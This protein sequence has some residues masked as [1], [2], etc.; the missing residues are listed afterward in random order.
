[1]KPAPT[2]RAATGGFP[3]VILFSVLLVMA[4][5][6]GD[7]GKADLGCQNPDTGCVDGEPCYGTSDCADE[8]LCLRENDSDETGMC[9][10]SPVTKCNTFVDRWCERNDFCETDTKELCLRRTAETIDCALATYVSDTYDDCLLEIDNLSCLILGE[11]PPSC[12]DM[13]SFQ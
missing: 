2:N 3:A 1:M 7:D 9:S 13:I 5:C 4:A 6:G 10:V 12:W 8:L 11:L